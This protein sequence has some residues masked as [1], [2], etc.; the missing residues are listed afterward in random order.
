MDMEFKPSVV[1]RHHND[2]QEGLDVIQVEQPGFGLRHMGVEHGREQA[3]RRG[4]CLECVVCVRQR[5]GLA[6]LFG[7]LLVALHLGYAEL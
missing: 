1:S 2:G 7:V 5:L 6:L 4:P 3:F